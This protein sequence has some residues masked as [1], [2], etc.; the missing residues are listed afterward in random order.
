M[1]TAASFGRRA[2]ARTDTGE[3]I[4]IEGP[5]DH[6]P[7]IRRFAHLGGVVLRFVHEPLTSRSFIR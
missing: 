1:Q 7:P 6:I 2:L 5:G 4:W 3:L